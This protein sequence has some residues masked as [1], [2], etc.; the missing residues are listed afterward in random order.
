MKSRPFAGVLEVLPKAAG[1]FEC[2]RLDVVFEGAP[3]NWE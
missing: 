3:E 2:W 1:V